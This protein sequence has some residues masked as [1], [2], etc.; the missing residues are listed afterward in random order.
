VSEPADPRVEGIDLDGVSGVV[1][2][3][4]VFACK[5]RAVVRRAAAHNANRR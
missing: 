2:G 1:F 4:D 3:F 5:Q